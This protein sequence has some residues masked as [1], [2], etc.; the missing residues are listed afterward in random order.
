MVCESRALTM[1][2]SRCI[3]VTVTCCATKYIHY[4][5]IGNLSILPYTSCS[6]IPQF[7]SIPM[8]RPALSSPFKSPRHT[9]LPPAAPSNRAQ[10][11]TYKTPPAHDRRYSKRHASNRPALP[12]MPLRPRW[13]PSCSLADPQYWS[14]PSRPDPHPAPSITRQAPPLAEQGPAHTPASTSPLA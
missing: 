9:I 1:Y 6:T 8:R 3:R 2:H 5:H 14:V 12:R 7:T 11:M 10:T 13:R 4:P